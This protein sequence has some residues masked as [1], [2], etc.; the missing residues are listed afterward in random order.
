MADSNTFKLD[1]YPKGDLW[2]SATEAERKGYWR[3]LGELGIAR[4]RWELNRGLDVDGKQMIPVQQ[5]RPDG[6]D[7]P[8]LSPHTAG[9]RSQK[10]LRATAGKSHVT[11][12]WSHGWGRILGYHADGVVIGAYRRDVIGLTPAGL[13]KVYE[14]A[15]RWFKRTVKPAKPKPPPKPATPPPEPAKPTRLPMRRVIAAKPIERTRAGAR[16][17]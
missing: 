16:P 10:W 1:R 9:S 8:P 4:K 2:D 12:W 15:E 5:P 17:R 3:K 7:G 11:I 6:A 14:E 13:K